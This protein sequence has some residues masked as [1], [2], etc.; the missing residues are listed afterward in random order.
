MDP[1]GDASS[2]QRKISSEK[3]SSQPSLLKWGFTCLKE[4]WKLP[5]SITINEEIITL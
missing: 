1:L 3:T 5:S 2:V 4:N